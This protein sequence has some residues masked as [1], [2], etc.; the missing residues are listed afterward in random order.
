MF[1]P[2]IYGDIAMS[3]DEKAMLTDILEQVAIV[4]AISFLPGSSV[5]VCIVQEEDNFFFFHNKFSYFELMNFHYHIIRS[6]VIHCAAL[7]YQKPV[8]AQCIAPFFFSCTPGAMN[9]ATTDNLLHEKNGVYSVRP[10]LLMTPDEQSQHKG[11]ST[12]IESSYKRQT[13][14]FV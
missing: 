6:C 2:W 9:C 3:I 8:D 7:P 14:R 10:D 13:G 12:V 1:V 11:T 5:D 4:Q